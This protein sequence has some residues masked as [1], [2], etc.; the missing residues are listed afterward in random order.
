VAGAIENQLLTLA[1]SHWDIFAM[2]QD[3]GN[4]KVMD[5]KS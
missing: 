1:D 3:G 2:A 4:N 5:T